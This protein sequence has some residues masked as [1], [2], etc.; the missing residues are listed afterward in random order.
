MTIVRLRSDGKL[1]FAYRLV[2]SVGDRR[3]VKQVGITV[4]ESSV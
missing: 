1:I 2:A 4:E 3:R